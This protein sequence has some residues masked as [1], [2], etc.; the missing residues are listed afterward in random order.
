MLF[1]LYS[2]IIFVWDAILKGNETLQ[3][4]AAKAL[5]KEFYKRTHILINKKVYTL[6]NV[7][8]DD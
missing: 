1:K 4:C 5:G 7:N 6:K 8:K 2:H 3:E